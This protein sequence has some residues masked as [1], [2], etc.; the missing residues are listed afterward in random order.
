MMVKGHSTGGFT[1]NGSKWY[2]QNLRGVAGDG[3]ETNDHFGAA[4]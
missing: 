3:A 2:H 1:S 4:L